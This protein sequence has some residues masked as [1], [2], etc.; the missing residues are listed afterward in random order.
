MGIM[1]IIKEITS[2]QSD[3]PVP[4]HTYLLNKKGKV[5]AY[6]SEKTGTL[7]QLKNGFILNKRYRKFINVNNPV[8]LELSKTIKDDKVIIKNNNRIFKVKSKDKE[9]QVEY[10]N[11]SLLC[12][13]VGFGFRGK[14]K[15][16]DAVSKQLG[17]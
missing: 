3:F 13:C 11:K 14:C 6:L 4:N 8:L 2:W 1:E 17:L 10:D 12:T 7:F 15:H 16:I 5:I 9:Y